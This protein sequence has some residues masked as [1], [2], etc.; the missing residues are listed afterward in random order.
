[1]FNPIAW[2]V[3][4]EHRLP[5]AL[6]T[7]NPDLFADYIV[8][9]HE[10][11]IVF[12]AIVMSFAERTADKPSLCRIALDRLGFDGDPSAAL[13]IDNRKDLVHAWQTGRGWLLVSERRTVA[14]RHPSPSW[15]IAATEATAYARAM[16]STSPHAGSS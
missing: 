2:R 9:A 10:L 8:P 12:D 16:T 15:P 3:A 6:V 11:A 1:M 5:Q 4:V 14:S 13:L 7:V